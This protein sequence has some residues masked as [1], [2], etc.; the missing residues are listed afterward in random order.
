MDGVTPALPCRA[1]L[2]TVRT[3]LSTLPLEFENWN[4]NSTSKPEEPAELYEPEVST[5]HHQLHVICLSW[6]SIRT[7][8]WAAPQHR[9]RRCRDKGERPL[10][11]QTPTFRSS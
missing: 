9:H 4:E 11:I 1:M 8:A 3:F 7:P 2:P 10:T 5:S 6:I